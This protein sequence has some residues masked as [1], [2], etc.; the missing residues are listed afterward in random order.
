MSTKN[1]LL[2]TVGPLSLLGLVDV[3]ESPQATI[4]QK[5]FL[6]GVVIFKLPPVIA[7]S[8][9]GNRYMFCL[10]LL[11]LL[12]RLR[13]YLTATIG[14]RFSRRPSVLI[15]FRRNASPEASS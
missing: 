5:V 1:V 13:S 14:R 12:G 9:R 3:P 8:G 15:Y 7:H 2:T 4:T 6:A 10:I 11:V